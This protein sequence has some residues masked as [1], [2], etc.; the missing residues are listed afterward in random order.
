MQDFS[1]QY[2]LREGADPDK[3]VLGIPTYGRSYTLINPEAADIGSPAEGPGEKGD[4]TKEQGYLAYYEICHRVKDEDWTV[5]DVDP[6]ALGPYAFKDNQWVGYDDE[7]IARKKSR[8]VVE[9]G[10][11]GIMFWSIDNDDFRGDC[12]GKPFPIIEAAKAALLEAL[13][14]SEITFDEEPE[15]VKSKTKGVVRQKATKKPEVQTSTARTTTNYRTTGSTRGRSPS[16]RASTTPRPPSEDHKTTP[17]PPTTPS[18]EG[19]KIQSF[20]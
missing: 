12:H 17:A 14:I 10:L 9:K 4:F 13:G 3:L 7:E 20:R 19:G 2:Y 5:V 1:I 18:S 11:G 8:Y 6:N 16:V 15:P